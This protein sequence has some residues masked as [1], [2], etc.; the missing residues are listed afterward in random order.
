VFQ[1]AKKKTAAPA[2]KAPEAA[3]PVT[4]VKTEEPTTSRPAAGG[5]GKKLPAAL[6]KLQQQQ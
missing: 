6:A 5:K 2:A 3:K 4:E 1:A